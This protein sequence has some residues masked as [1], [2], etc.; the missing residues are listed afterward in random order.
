MTKYERVF[1]YA[2]PYRSDAYAMDSGH[3]WDRLAAIAGEY[4][5]GERTWESARQLCDDNARDLA[6][7]L[8][9]A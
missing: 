4:E 3:G 1:A 5:R 8:A 6:A 9:N 2:D 7:N